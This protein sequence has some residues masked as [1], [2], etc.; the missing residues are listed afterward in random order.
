MSCLFAPLFCRLNFS[1]FS[2]DEGSDKELD[3]DF[4]VENERYMYFLFHV[5]VLP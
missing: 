1:M 3:D 5:K 2:G 4:F